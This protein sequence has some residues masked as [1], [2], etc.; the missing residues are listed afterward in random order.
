MVVPVLLGISLMWFPVGLLLLGKGEARGTGALTLMVGT[1][2]IVGAIII[3]TM[4][5]PIVG[6]LLFA[7][8]FFYNIVGYSLYAG[9]TD[10]RS[11]GNASATVGLITIVYIILFLTG[12]PVWAP[13][14]YMALACAGY[15]V[16][17]IMVW[18]NAYGKFSGRTLGWSLIIWT[19]VG[20]W[21]PAFTLLAMGKLPF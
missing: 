18:L 9:L 14:G 3:A 16:L 17:Y 11:V 7:Y 13:N 2:T 19:F 4:G 12:G 8:G 5:D 15:L 1:L 10:P 20:L 21:W 6:G